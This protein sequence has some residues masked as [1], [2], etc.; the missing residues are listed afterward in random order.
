MSKSETSSQT[1]TREKHFF[2]RKTLSFQLVFFFEIDH[3]SV[4]ESDFSVVVIAVVVVVVIIIVI[5]IAVVIADLILGSI[6]MADLLSHG[7]IAN[8]LSFRLGNCL[9]L[10]RII[11]RIDR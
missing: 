4:G 10:G 3:F 8:R 1:S 5:V 7:P 11:E 9:E 6:P 2:P